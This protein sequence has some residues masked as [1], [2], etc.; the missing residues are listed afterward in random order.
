MLEVNALSIASYVFHF[1]LSSK[2]KNELLDI[3]SPSMH[4][5]T[6]ATQVFWAARDKFIRIKN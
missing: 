5:R 4:S 1:V 2:K 6:F 3:N